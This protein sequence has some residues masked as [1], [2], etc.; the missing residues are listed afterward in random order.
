MQ[1]RRPVTPSKFTRRGFTLIELL[2][3]ISI[4]AVL[5]SL[6]LPAVQQAREAGRRTQCQNNLKNVGLAALGFAEAHRGVL[7]S[8]GTYKDFNT[9]GDNIANT[10][11]ASHSWAIDLLPYMDQQAL[12]DRWNFSLPF[13]N[14]ANAAVGQYNL[15]VL[16]CPNDKTA[17]GLNGA[18]SYVCNMGY[19]DTLADITDPADPTTFGQLPQI[20]T[21]NWDGVT[22]VNPNDIAVAED[23]AM[24]SAFFDLPATQNTERKS[25]NVGRIYD[26]AGNTI[27]FIENVNGG[28]Q[29][30]GS[31]TSLLPLNGQ[32]TFADPSL[33]SCGFFV[34][35]TGAAPNN[36]ISAQ[37]L[38]PAQAFINKSKDGPDGDRPYPNG[39]HVGI[40]VAAFADGTVRILSD[41]IDPGVYTRLVTPSGARKRPGITG[42]APE[43]P[44]SDNDF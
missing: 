32:G 22:G 15:A 25:Q 43:N 4:I 10:A 17:S 18:L 39:Q 21:L 19:G 14:A 23:S 6:I 8:S 20:E 35:M 5:M 44:L 1:T 38:V 3:V 31:H 28:Q 29:A 2:V 9:D 34:P 16:T 7:P 40:I 41:T 37:N 13:N 27:M 11:E 36:Y 24:F 33:R 42:F 26:G 12:Y 30:A